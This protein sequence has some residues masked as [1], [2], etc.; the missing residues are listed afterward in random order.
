MNQQKESKELPVPKDIRLAKQLVRIM[1]EWVRIPIINKRV[2]LDPIIG[3][4]PVVGDVATSLI[5][6]F[7]D[8]P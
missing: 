7:S 8:S 5:S 1:D 4:I 3:L 6:L 2:G